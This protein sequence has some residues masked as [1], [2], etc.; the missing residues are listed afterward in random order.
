MTG[1]L[2]RR[3]SLTSTRWKRGSTSNIPPA[4]ISRGSKISPPSCT[5]SSPAARPTSD[6]RISVNVGVSVCLVE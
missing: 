2:R 5:L 1:I 3:H 4:P 6:I